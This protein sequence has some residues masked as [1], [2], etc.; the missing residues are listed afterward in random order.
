MVADED[1][2]R[3]VG[4]SMALERFEQQ[5]HADIEPLNLVVVAGDALALLRRVDLLER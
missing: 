4:V 2:Q 1:D 5:A 3:V